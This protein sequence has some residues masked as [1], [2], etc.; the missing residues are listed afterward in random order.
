[1]LREVAE[2][3][4]CAEL[5]LAFLERDL[6]SEELDERGFARAIRTDE[7]GALATLDFEVEAF[8]HLLGAVG[9]VDVV[10]GNEALAAALRLREVET[11]AFAQRAWLIELIHLFELAL[12]ALRL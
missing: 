8:V 5:A 12:A 11:E 6:A 2:L 3:E 4:V 7:H 1:M 10:Q 9:L